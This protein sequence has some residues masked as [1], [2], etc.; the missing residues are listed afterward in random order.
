MF[1]SNFLDPFGWG[2]IYFKYE[3]QHFIGLIISLRVLS[4]SVVIIFACPLFIT[5][6]ISTQLYAN[7]SWPN[8]CATQICWDVGNPV[9]CGWLIH[10]RKS[11]QI[12]CFHSSWV[13]FGYFCYSR[14]KLNFCLD[15]LNVSMQL[16]T[17]SAQQ[18]LHPSQLPKD[19]QWQHASYSFSL[20]T[21]H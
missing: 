13:N 8:E 21:L 18:P 11:L 3:K 6:F 9:E 17:T 1:M 10:K 15:Y 19:L 7:Y 12:S 4:K 5:P 14:K 2:E 20:F 16:F